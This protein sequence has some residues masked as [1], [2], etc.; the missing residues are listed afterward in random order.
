MRQFN[1]AILLQI[2]PINKSK[3]LISTTF[4]IL[5]SFFMPFTILLFVLYFF[6]VAVMAPVMI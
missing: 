3:H 5:H 1:I 2:E 4:R 6:F